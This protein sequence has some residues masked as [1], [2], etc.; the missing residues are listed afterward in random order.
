MSAAV[1]PA[2]PSAD[3]EDTL[4]GDSCQHAYKGRAAADAEPTWRHALVVRPG[5]AGADLS[6]AIA[7]PGNGQLHQPGRA[8]GLP[9]GVLELENDDLEAAQV[10]LQEA[11]AIALSWL[12][13]L[14][15]AGHCWA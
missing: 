13:A 15:S 11:V 9:L 7:V 10:Y 6:E 14:S 5:R 12:H 1:S 2:W 4:T 3:K 8:D